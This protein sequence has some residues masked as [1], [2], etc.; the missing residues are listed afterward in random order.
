MKLR[1]VPIFCQLTP[2][3][4]NFVTS[5][6]AIFTRSKTWFG[7]AMVI[8]SITCEPLASPAIEA[9]SL[10]TL[11]A[12]PASDTTPLSTRLPSTELAEIGSPGTSWRNEERSR[13]M[14]CSTR[15]G[16][17]SSTLSDASTA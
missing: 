16:A 11:S 3:S 15:I 17:L 5:T 1:L 9:A 4:F 8:R 12:W 7:V 2:I 14:S 13:E 6:S 10:L